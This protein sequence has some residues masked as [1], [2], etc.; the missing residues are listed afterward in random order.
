MKYTKTYI[1][2]VCNIKFIDYL[3][4]KRTCCSRTCLNKYNSII[5]KGISLKHFIGKEPWNKGKKLPEYSGNNNG[6]WK[7]G[8]YLGSTG[9]VYILNK[10]HP[11]AKKNGYVAEHR[12]VIEKYIGRYITNIESIHHKNKIRNDNRIENLMLLRNKSSHN[13]IDRGL[14]ISK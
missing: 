4:E 2:A 14:K 10:E 6:H 3:S 9:Y 5:K 11:Y 12:M 8:R 1:C 13:R 7:G